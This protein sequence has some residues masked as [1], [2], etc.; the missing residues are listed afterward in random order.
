M[1]ML[2]LIFP[3]QGTQKIGMGKDFFD[4]YTIARQVFE[5][6]NDLLGWNVSNLC[7]FGSDLELRQTR[8]AQV[9]IFVV[10]IAILKSIQN[11]ESVH[12]S[13]LAGHSLGEYSALVASGALSFSEGLRIVSKR[14]QLMEEACQ[15]TH[16]MLAVI[17][18]SLNKVETLCEDFNQNGFFIDFACYNTPEQCVLAGDISVLSRAVEILSEWGAKTSYL[19][20]SGAFHSRYMQTKSNVFRDELEKISWKKM[21]NTVIS[22]VSGE[23]YP[24]DRKQWIE[25]LSK[26]LCHPINWL[27]TIRFLYLRG[28]TRFLEIGPGNILSHLNHSIIPFVETYS[29]SSISNVKNG[30]VFTS[31]TSPS[32]IGLAFIARSLAYAV[33]TKNSYSIQS[34]FEEEC[35]KPYLEILNYYNTVK[36]TSQEV[37]AIDCR[38]A[39]EMLKLILTKKCITQEEQNLRWQELSWIDS[40]NVL[41]KKD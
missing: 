32:S 36:D 30:L 26:Q 10:E 24:E 18:I 16:G 23:P 37:S 1:S 20:V 25:L 8:L 5:E 17:G 7:F 21:K 9:A 28:V 12:F 11:E 38:K 14:A 41:N 34:K 31:K 3:G 13:F 27:K 39:V 15:T 22:N 33:A 6:A 40:F 29:I 2:A 19:K 35:R 4:S